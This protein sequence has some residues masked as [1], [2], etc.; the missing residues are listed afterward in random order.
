MNIDL[1]RF[2]RFYIEARKYD[3]RMN[4]NSSCGLVCA[5]TEQERRGANLV[6]SNP[7]KM[8][9]RPLFSN[10]LGEKGSHSFLTEERKT[11][12]TDRDRA[13]E[14]GLI[15]EIGFSLSCIG[16]MGNLRRDFLYASLLQKKWQCV[17]LVSLS[18]SQLSQLCRSLNFSLAPL[19][20]VQLTVFHH[21]ILAI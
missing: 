5:H 17:R 18:S 9:S 15:G 4:L 2:Y 21:P 20:I 8:Q 3:R 10:L 16:E 12:R 13:R 6:S 1:H 11:D 19:A 7:A 14:I